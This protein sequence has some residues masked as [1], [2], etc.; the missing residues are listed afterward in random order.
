MLDN[1]NPVFTSVIGMYKMGEIQGVPGDHEVEV[2][3]NADSY[4]E[5]MKSLFNFD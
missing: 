2:I 1:Y 3:D 5:H 4:V